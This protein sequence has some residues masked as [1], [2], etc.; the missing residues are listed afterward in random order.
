[1]GKCKV[2]PH[3]PVLT[4]PRLELLACVLST[5]LVQIVHKE[6]SLNSKDFFWTD[7]N[8]VLCYNKSTSSMFKVFVANRIQ[9]IHDR[10]EVEDWFHVSSENNPADDGS[11]GKRSERWLSGPKFLFERVLP[12][13]CVIIWALL[14]SYSHLC[15]HTVVT[16]V[17]IRSPVLSYSHLKVLYK[18]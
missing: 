1:M 9:I 16:C 13:I 14:L 11:R 8:I 3:K 2:I 10:T 15:H 12:V 4:M 17:I 7:S 6:L 18:N 5:R